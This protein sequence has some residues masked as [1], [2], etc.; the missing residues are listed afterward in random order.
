MS[1]AP[2]ASETPFS[3]TLDTSDVDGDTSVTAGPRAF[4][5]LH[6]FLESKT[7]YGTTVVIPHSSACLKHLDGSS[8]ATAELLGG[9]SSP[10]IA[11]PDGRRA[12]VASLD[13]GSRSS[14]NG[15]S[16]RREGRRRS[17]TSA[18]L[19]TLLRKDFEAAQ[20]TT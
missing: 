16:M 18:R 6:G 15:L 9:P 4:T 10:F 12:S 14:S 20:G 7:L 8:D 13:T 11:S 3:Q 19:V 1:A 5:S 2:K 17:L